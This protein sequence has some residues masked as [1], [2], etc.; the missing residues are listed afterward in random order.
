MAALSGNPDYLHGA[1]W[2]VVAYGLVGLFAGLALGLIFS[3]VRAGRDAQSAYAFTWSLVFCSLAWFVTRYRL[4][5][6]LF[7][8]SIRTFSLQGL[9]FNG[10]LLLAFAALFFLLFWLWRRPILRPISR[11]LTSVACFLLVAVAAAVISFV[12]RPGEELAVAPA[13]IPPGLEDA[14]NI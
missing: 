8:E 7:H 4:Y 6:D 11:A 12:A 14:P 10:G 3:A 2:A 13:G 5:R 1:L 9:L